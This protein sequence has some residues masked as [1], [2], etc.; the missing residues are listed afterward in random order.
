[1]NTDMD[2]KDA[3]SVVDKLKLNYPTLKAQGLIEKYNVQAFPTLVV[4][5]QKGVIRG[6]H[7]GYPTNLRE[8]V[9]KNITSLLSE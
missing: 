9:S 3:R 1:M 2:E 5:D 4:I 6:W 7:L 8:L